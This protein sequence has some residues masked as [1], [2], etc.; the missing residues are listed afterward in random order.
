M[1]DTTF[2]VNVQNVV[3][4]ISLVRFRG[5]WVG[6]SSSR[7]S[8]GLYRKYGGGGGLGLENS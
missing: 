4:V 7:C 2:K 6:L 1:V 8:I 3:Y 5:C